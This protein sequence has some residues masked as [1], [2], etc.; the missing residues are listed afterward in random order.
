MWFTQP[1]IADLRYSTYSFFYFREGTM[2]QSRTE[3]DLSRYQS[4]DNDFAHLSLKNLVDA[5]ELFH[6]HLM[7]HP[8]V[9]ATAIG[10][11][12]IRK[13]D[14]WP[15][16]KHARKG[17]GIRRLDN[18]EVRP[19][20]W[21]SILVFVS[22]WE[23]PDTFASNPDELVP[24]TIFMPDG[25]KVPICVIEAPKEHVNPVEAV[26]IR[27]PL[28]NMGPGSPIIAE[29]QGQRYAATVGCLVSDGHS[30]YALTNRHVTGPAGA[31]VL[32]LIDGEAERIGLSSHKQLTRMPLSTIYPNLKADDTF[33]N[34]DIGLIELD[35]IHNWTAQFPG[36]GISG[37]MADFSSINL[38]LSLVGCHVR[39]IGAASGEMLGE[40][41]GLFYRYKTGGG[42]E[43]VSDIYIGPRTS[44]DAGAKQP[45]P[46]AT[47][48]GDSGTLWLLEPLKAAK[49]KNQSNDAAPQYLP[50]AVQWGR[51]M[52]YSAEASPPQTFVLATLLSRICAL[53]EVDPVRDWNIDQPDTWGAL[54]HF[55]IATRAQV[56]LANFPKLKA[57]MARH[58]TV[59]SRSDADLNKGE[60]KGMGSA[61]FVPMADVP[62]FYWKKRVA[63]QGFAR[64]F[65][66]A[67]HFADMDQER[68][69]GKTLLELTKQDEWIDPD[70]WQSFYNEIVDLGTDK[71]IAVDRRGLLPF[72]VWQ[73][74][75]AMCEFAAEDEPGK[76]VCAA[77]VLA[78]YIGDACQPL[79]I[80]YLH[81]GDPLQPVEHV[82]TRG[83]N[84]G[85][86]VTKNLGEGVHKAYEDVMI[87][88]N[89]SDILTGLK[90]T[91][92]VK[93][94]ELVDSGF[95]AAKATIEM[96]RFTYKSL[97]PAKIVQAFANVGKGGKAASDALWK[98]FGDETIETM[99][100]GSH[101]LALL[102]ESAW[103][104]GSGEKNITGKVKLTQDQAMEIVADEHFLPSMTI[105]SIGEV[106][107]Q[108]DA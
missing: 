39:G 81:D 13:S 95:E 33:V 4:A 94:S 26:D 66:G 10:R 27:R 1:S 24:K 11:Y 42:F 88:H 100:A 104:I 65:E 62:D 72:R 25:S 64:D 16:E 43:Y 75:D 31:E 98:R 106:L 103:Q 71:K 45:I 80:S 3:I 12:R 105:A 57:L 52:L 101:L 73:I 60:F 76:F 79:H 32:G 5:R 85:K 91:K 49:S 38:S 47:L 107:N 30:I 20:S 55:S 51:N 69:D 37:P 2:G 74:F 99:Q 35:E 56:A 59:I 22:K 58:E 8:N 89:R 97:P 48:P 6:I 93:K 96:M 15:H 19:Y 108:A 102:W 63:K 40:I 23:N 90:K 46:F 87:F 53:L 61:D 7:R 36:I 78:H 84:E 83:E 67:N 21:P 92:K 86:T 17:T 77:G 68:P 50:L 44:G 14:S 82:I 9:V 54:G 29:V 28:N 70:K 34:V 18:S 41:H